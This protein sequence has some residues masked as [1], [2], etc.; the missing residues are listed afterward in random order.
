METEDSVYFYGHSDKN[1]GYLSNFWISPFIDENG[2][3]FNCTEKYLMYMKAKT[4]E[5]NN[6]KLLEDILTINSPPVLKKIGRK[7]KNYDDEIWSGIRFNIMVNGLRLKFSQNEE[8]KQ[9]LLGTENKLLYEAS[10]RD[11]IWGIGFSLKNAIFVNVEEYGLNLLGKALM[12]I[13]DEL[14]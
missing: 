11:K 10:S 13:R 14:K 7:V 6:N 8:L 5:Q 12:V 4:F 1:Y 3:Y 9:R 2:T